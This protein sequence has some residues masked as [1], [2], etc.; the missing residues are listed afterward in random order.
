MFT[1]YCWRKSEFVYFLLT[2]IQLVMSSDFLSSVCIYLHID[3]CR[4]PLVE[5]NLA[6]LTL[7]LAKFHGQ[8]F[9][10]SLVPHLL[11]SH[12][13]HTNTAP[14]PLCF[15]FHGDTGVGKTFLSSLI[16]KN[17]YRYGMNSKFVKVFYLEKGLLLNMK[18]RKV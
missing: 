8:P 9:A 12:F 14:G 4:K 3:C 17:I 11:E 1:G 7:D 2:C 10:S 6:S 16:I 13:Y 5:F 18:Q 15:Y